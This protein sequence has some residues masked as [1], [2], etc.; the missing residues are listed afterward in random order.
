MYAGSW[1]SGHEPPA[2]F[3]AEHQPPAASLPL[4]PLCLHHCFSIE[5]GGLDSVE[6]ISQELVT[7]GLIDG[8]DLV[9]VAANLQKIIDNKDRVK[10]LVFAMVKGPNISL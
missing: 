10:N 6:G 8:R 3:G 9:V 4:P 1:G 7:A 5:N 2:G